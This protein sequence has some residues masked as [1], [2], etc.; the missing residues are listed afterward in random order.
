MSAWRGEQICRE[1]LTCKTP[2][3]QFFEQF[4]FV[5]FR[6]VGKLEKS[7]IDIGC[8][9]HFKRSDNS[10][11]CCMVNKLE[12]LNFFDP[13]VEVFPGSRSQ[14]HVQTFATKFWHVQVFQTK[15]RQVQNLATMM[16]RRDYRDRR[17]GG[18]TKT[19][20]LISGNFRLSRLRV[21]ISRLSR[22]KN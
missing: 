19:S 3:E 15:I 13:S 21:A 11:K 17:G 10:L 2:C 7:P 22:P 20:W 18:A 12:V 4:H 1:F 6:G 14:T 5:T 9:T 8:W 16:I